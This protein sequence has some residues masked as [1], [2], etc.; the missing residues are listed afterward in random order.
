M[1]KIPEE[2]GAQAGTINTIVGKGSVAEGVYHIDGGIRIDGELRGELSASDSVTVG[3]SGDVNVDMLKAKSM[4]IGGRVTGK[5]EVSGH[6]RLQ[7][8]S[9]FLGELRTRL[10]VVDEGAVFHGELLVGTEQ[11]TD[12]VVRVEQA[13][14]SGGADGR[15]DEAV[16]R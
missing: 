4:V 5:L 1:K 16:E 6:T 10:L 8:T 15:S 9:V 2:S 13:L 7:A 12:E 11:G 3:P 14:E